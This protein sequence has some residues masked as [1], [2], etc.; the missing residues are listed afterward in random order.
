MAFSPC[1]CGSL[2]LPHN[3][4]NHLFAILNDPCK[5]G[6]CLLVMASSIKD[7]RSYDNSCILNAGDHPFIKH[8]TYMVYRLA[9][10]W[11]VP[12]LISW[13]EKKIA[14]EKDRFTNAILDKIIEGLEKSDETRQR[15]LTYARGIGLVV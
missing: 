10:E 15:V 7:G 1:R 8:P 9:E 6:Y 13:I 4:E 2:L 3:G 5:D 12:L 11:R 14:V